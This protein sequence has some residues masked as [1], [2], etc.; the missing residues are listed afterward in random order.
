MFIVSN[1]KW[2]LYFDKWRPRIV[3]TWISG[4]ETAIIHAEDPA[5]Q[6]E[7]L[8]TRLRYVGVRNHVTNPVIVK[9]KKRKR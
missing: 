4:V 2:T 5:A 9:H 1:D 6:V 8:K 3:R 7:E